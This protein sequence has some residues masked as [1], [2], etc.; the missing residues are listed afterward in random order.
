MAIATAMCCY[1]NLVMTFYAYDLFASLH[2]HSYGMY[3]NVAIYIS[4][5]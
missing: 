1:V 4:Y 2:V 5:T 3:N